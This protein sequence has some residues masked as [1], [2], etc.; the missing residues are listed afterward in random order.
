MK[1]SSGG[2]GGLVFDYYTDADF[3]YV[4]LD[5]AAGAVVVGT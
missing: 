3:K 2:R 4:T 1:A 5:L